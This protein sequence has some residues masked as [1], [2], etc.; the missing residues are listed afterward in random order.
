MA[1]LRPD[2]IVVAVVLQSVR[3]G[4]AVVHT[5]NVVA[6]S[7]HH[8]D[9]GAVRPEHH[10]EIVAV[11]PEHHNVI[12]VVRQLNDIDYPDRWTLL[13]VDT[14]QAAPGPYIPVQ[15]QKHRSRYIHMTE[16]GDAGK[17][18]D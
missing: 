8:T 1:V 3:I 4:N 11:R 15:Q 9:I 14:A 17:K 18:Y 12:A 2:H 16:T 13:E 7:E 5:G 6:Q 10:T